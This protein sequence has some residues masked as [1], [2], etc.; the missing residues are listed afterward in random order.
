MTRTPAIIRFIDPAS[1]ADPTNILSREEQDRAAS[2]RF[3]KDRAHWIACRSG[4]KK[5]LAE[6]LGISPDSVPIVTGPHGK[7]ELAPPSDILRF[8]LSHCEDMALVI[9]ADTDV[10]IDVERTDRGPSLIGCE[11]SFCHPREI[12]GLSDSPVE[13]ANSLITIWTAKEAALKAIGTGLLHDPT[14]VFIDF[15]SGRA[16]P[17]DPIPALG[18]I[19]IERLAHPRLDAHSAFAAFPDSPPGFLLMD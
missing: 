6:L 5:I 13:R 17:D 12:A 9:T 2:F 15:T 14:R 8:N 16:I 10:G 19:R 11:E 7:P 18:S 1:G 3:E 4:L